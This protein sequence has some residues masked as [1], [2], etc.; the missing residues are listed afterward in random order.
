[1]DDYRQICRPTLGRKSTDTPPI[2]DL[3]S[4]YSRSIFD[5]QSAVISTDMSTDTLPIVDQHSTD[6]R[7]ICRSTPPIRHMILFMLVLTYTQKYRF[8]RFSCLF[9]LSF[10]GIK[11]CIWT[12]LHCHHCRGAELSTYTVKQQHVIHFDLYNNMALHVVNPMSLW[13]L[14]WLNSYEYEQN[15]F[16]TFYPNLAGVSGDVESCE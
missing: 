16:E 9:F 5:R 7:P 1:M 15:S 4:T 3:Y 13:N 6:T 11:E 8:T 14:S 10:L 12:S 2:L